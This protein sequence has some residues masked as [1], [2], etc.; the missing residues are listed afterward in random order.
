MKIRSF[1]INGKLEQQINILNS[2]NKKK[3]ERE[4]HLYNTIYTLDLESDS[5][6]TK[7]VNDKVS[8]NVK[9]YVPDMLVGFASSY[10]T[11]GK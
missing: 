8:F 9:S 4:S 5:S 3:W 2:Q 11:D 10:V 6:L 7:F 1:L